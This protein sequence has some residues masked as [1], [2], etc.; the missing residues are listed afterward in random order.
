MHDFV[1]DYEN[2]LNN[3][4]INKYLTQQKSLKR[5]NKI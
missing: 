1:K 4:N 2:P 3:T 5:K